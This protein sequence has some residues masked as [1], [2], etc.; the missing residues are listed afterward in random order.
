MIAD[1]S[2]DVQDLPFRLHRVLDA[3]GS[4]E[5]EPQRTRDVDR[6]VIDG[7]LIAVEMPLQFDVHAIASEHFHQP[8]CNAP[9]FFRASV[10]DGCGER[11]AISSRQADQTCRVRNHFRFCDRALSFGRAHFHLRDQA[12]EVLIAG[13]AGGEKVRPHWRAG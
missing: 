12:A 7:F 9:A 6:P 1:A 5:R 11:A 3:V 4:D 2:E 8:F 13:A 10:A